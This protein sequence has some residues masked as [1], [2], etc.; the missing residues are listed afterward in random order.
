MDKIAS[1]GL[2]TYWDINKGE[3]RN[4]MQEDLNKKFQFFKSLN[5]INQM[6]NGTQEFV[7]QVKKELFTENIYV[8]TTKGEV[9]ELPIGSIPIDFAYKIHT[10]VG[11]MMVGAVV[12]DKYVP[13]DYILQNK[14]RVRIITDTLAYGPK[15]E[16]IDKVQTTTAKRKIK[17]FCG[18][19]S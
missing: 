3:A 14:D 1:F 11:N 8:Y 13:L 19:V 16:W 2:T 15:P 6:T 17:E 10:E 4:V 12:N 9:I 18:K 7:S 5:E